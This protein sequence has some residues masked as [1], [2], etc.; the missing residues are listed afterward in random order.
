M[1]TDNPCFLQIHGLGYKA[2][3]K[4]LCKVF[5][6]I[7]RLEGGRGSEEDQWNRSDEVKKKDEVPLV[8]AMKKH[9]KKDNKFRS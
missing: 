2:L 9:N 4:R 3:K 1:Y 5:G 7:H 8:M 6:K